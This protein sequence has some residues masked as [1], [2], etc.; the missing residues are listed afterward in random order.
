MKKKTLF[1]VPYFGQKECFPME[2]PALTISSRRL[3]QPLGLSRSRTAVI[4]STVVALLG[5]CIPAFA[6]TPEE[7]RYIVVLKGGPARAAEV[8]REHSARHGAQVGRV[9]E[10]ALKG[11][12]AELVPHEVAQV[13]RDPR[14]AF[15]EPD[16]ISTIGV[17]QSSATWGLDRI[18]QA[19][20]PLNR[21]FN[22]VRTGAGVTVYILD[23]GIRMS[24]SQFGG[25]AV[26]GFD[27]IDNDAD[28]SDCQGHGTHV[29]GTAGGSSYG[30]AKGAT[31]MSV[32][33]LDCYGSGYNSGIIAGVDWVTA[34]HQ[35]GVPAVANMSLGGSAS[36][37]LDQA[38]QNSI[39]DGVTY[40][41]AAGNSTANACNYSPG[42]VPAALTT[43][44]S[45]STDA[46]ASFSNHGSCVD[47][48]APGAAITSAVIQSDTA[49]GTWNGT[50]MAAPHTAG[51]AAQYLQGNRTASPATVTSA[52][53]SIATKNKIRESSTS[54]K[55][56]LRTAY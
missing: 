47:W 10:N 55:P 32:R 52:L 6:G 41:V 3:A 8:A 33:V 23:T 56:L 45:T 42:R 43:G 20:L 30:V 9:Y 28:A 29:A 39:T 36:S 2:S 51:V 11:Y 46:K 17:T 13:K 19:S 37:A 44:A 53:S 26:S 48:Y 27:F 18:D 16:A 40:V 38:V 54:I 7:S 1:V 50:S 5:F 4:F 34:H 25:R 15:V 22:Y 21:T 12:A 14:V 35:A 49:T 31:L 24:H